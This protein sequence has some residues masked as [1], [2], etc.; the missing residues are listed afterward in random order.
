ML[1]GS[2]EQQQV[3]KQEQKRSSNDACVI[4]NYQN[5]F[6]NVYVWFVDVFLC[7]GIL[8][9]QPSYS[10]MACVKTKHIVVSRRLSVVLGF[11]VISRMNLL[12]RPS[13]LDDLKVLLF[14]HLVQLP[15]YMGPRTSIHSTCLA[16]QLLARSMQ[17]FIFVNQSIS[18]YQ[19]TY[20]L[21]KI[22]LIIVSNTVLYT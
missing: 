3:Q 12:K 2:E 21:R 19:R 8:L 7:K 16:I 13:H 11:E 6:P 14:S 1:C 10:S 5:K 22:S 15:S 4:P 18:L 9:F 17:H 20:Q